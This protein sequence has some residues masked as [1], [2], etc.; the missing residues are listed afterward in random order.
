M[1]TPN[2]QCPSL[3]LVPL[4]PPAWLCSK[5]TIHCWVPLAAM[6]KILICSQTAV[7][8][9]WPILPPI[10]VSVYLS[11]LPPLEAQVLRH[12]CLLEPQRHDAGDLGSIKRRVLPVR[13]GSTSPAS[14][15]RGVFCALHST[16]SQTIQRVNTQCCFTTAWR[17]QGRLYCHPLSQVR[18][19]DSEGE[20]TCW[21]RYPG[22]WALELFP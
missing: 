13:G 17:H 21:D 18:Y 8:S 9:Q 5:D 22:L 20:M 1:D 16:G 15:L 19:Q 6:V 7:H 14:Q 4:F 11:T 10:L 12:C 2:P 3:C